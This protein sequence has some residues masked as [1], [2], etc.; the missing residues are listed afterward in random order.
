MAFSWWTGTLASLIEIL[1]RVSFPKLRN[2]FVHIVWRLNTLWAVKWFD[3]L[4]PTFVGSC[5]QLRSPAMMA[6]QQS[7]TDKTDLG[8]VNTLMLDSQRYQLQ[9]CGSQCDDGYRLR[10]DLFLTLFIFIAFLNTSGH[11]LFCFFCHTKMK[12][13]DYVLFC[14]Y[15]RKKTMLSTFIPFCKLFPFYL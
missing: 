11:P 6:V 12:V 9:I 8:P 13:S 10:I 7:D 15:Y 3:L 5:T 4:R 14:G 1:G 2:G